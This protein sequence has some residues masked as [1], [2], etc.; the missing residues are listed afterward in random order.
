[1]ICTLI[2]QVYK[3]TSSLFKL[4]SHTSV[5]RVFQLEFKF[6]LTSCYIFIDTVQSEAII[7]LLYWSLH[8][9]PLDCLLIY[10]AITEVPQVRCFYIDRQ[11]DIQAIRRSRHLS[12]LQQAKRKTREEPWNCSTSVLLQ[13]AFKISKVCI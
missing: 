10:F 4:H 2:C 7:E 13:F 12:T 3:V 11:K 8:T 1:M 6:M 5:I 9:C